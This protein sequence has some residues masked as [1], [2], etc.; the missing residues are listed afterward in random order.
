MAVRALLEVGDRRR[1]GD[2][3]AADVIVLPKGGGPEAEEVKAVLLAFGRIRRCERRIAKLRES[4]TD[5][6]RSKA[7]RAIRINSIAVEGEAIQKIVADMPLK[8]VLINDLVSEM[9]GRC[10][11]TT[12]LATAARRGRTQTLTHEGR[13]LP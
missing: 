8:P 9:R 6:R 11:R 7:T 13:S 12:R 4:L 10:H 5:K 2:T 3:A 1:R